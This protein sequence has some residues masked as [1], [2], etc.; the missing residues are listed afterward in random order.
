MAR[1]V[2]FSARADD[3]LTGQGGDG[4]SCGRFTVDAN[5]HLINDLGGWIV[6]VAVGSDRGEVNLWLTGRAP[7]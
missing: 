4:G 1:C 6:S 5:S 3:P 2:C 7:A